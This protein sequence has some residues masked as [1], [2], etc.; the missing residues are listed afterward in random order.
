MARFLSKELKRL[1]LEVKKAN[2]PFIII[3]HVKDSMNP[4]GAKHTF[5]GG[6]TLRHTLSAN[7]Y[8]AGSTSKENLIL[9]EDDNK[10]GGLIMAKVEK[11]KFGPWPRKAEFTVDFNKGIVNAEKEVYELA[12][13]YKVIE[14]T[15]NITHEYNGNK[16]KGKPATMEA[17]A[18]D[19]AL[20]KELVNK[21][22]EARDKELLSAS[23][24]ADVEK[25][26][27]QDSED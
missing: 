26:T 7:V 18:S 5:S 4:Y 27:A 13:K 16:W 14:K 9:D 17:I 6:N 23:V 1:V 3:N 22:A 25:E 2:V 11:S 21:I 24:K 15:S 20:F 12:L 19:E 10:Q 8:F